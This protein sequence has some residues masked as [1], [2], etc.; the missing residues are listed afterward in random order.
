MWAKSYEM[1]TFPKQKAKGSRVAMNKG[2]QPPKASFQ[3]EKRSL[4]KLKR[5]CE[6]AASTSTKKEKTYTKTGLVG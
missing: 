6:K 1:Q 4:M 3:K 2:L 5:S